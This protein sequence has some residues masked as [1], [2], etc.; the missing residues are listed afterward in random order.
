MRIEKLECMLNLLFFS[1]NVGQLFG[2]DG[3]SFHHRI[4]EEYGAVCKVYGLL[5]VRP[6][7]RLCN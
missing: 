3:W 4:A 5:G 6:L 1:G 7:L 2:L